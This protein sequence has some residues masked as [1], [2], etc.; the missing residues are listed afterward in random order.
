[1]S[2]ATTIDE[3][4]ELTPSQYSNHCQQLNNV[5]LLISNSTFSMPNEIVNDENIST[6]VTVDADE[7]NLD[8]DPNKPKKTDKLMSWSTFHSNCVQPPHTLSNVAIVAPLYRRSPTNPSVLMDIMKRAMNITTLAIGRGKRTIITL[9]GDLYNRAVK[10]PNYKENWIIR[11]GSLHVIIAALKCLGK[12]VEGSGIDASWEES[13]MFGSATVNQVIEGRHIYRGIQMKKVLLSLNLK[14][15]LTNGN[16]SF[17]QAVQD[18]QKEFQAKKIFEK[19]D[20]ENTA[21]PTAKFLRNYMKQ[22]TNLLTYIAATRNRNWRQ[23]LG[24]TEKMTTYIHA[25]NQ[26]NY[27]KWMLLYLGDMLELETAD[28][29]S[30]DFLNDGN[31]CVSKNEIPFTSIDPDH[32]IEHEHKHFKV[33]GGFVGITGNEAALERF[34]ITMPILSNIAETFERYSNIKRSESNC[35]EHHEAFGNFFQ[36]QLKNSQNLINILAK[37]GNPFLYP[38]LRNLVNYSVP[39]DEIRENVIKRDDIGT[40]LVHLFR[41]QRMMEN[42]TI[43]F[44]STLPRT[45]L[46]VFSGTEIMVNNGEKL[47]TSIR[48]EKQMYARM[49]AISRTRSELCPD[50][51]IDF[52]NLFEAYEAK[53][54][55]INK[56]VSNQTERVNK[57]ENDIENNNR[58]SRLND[59]I[60]RGVPANQTDLLK[61]FVSIA[62]AI[63]FNHS[64]YDCVNNIFRIRGNKNTSPI[65]IQFT[66]SIYKREFMS[67]YFKFGQLKL[68]D[69]GCE[70]NSRIYVSDN[71]TKHNSDIH[72]KALQLIKDKRLSKVTTRSGFIF[73]QQLNSDDIVKVSDLEGLLKLCNENGSETNILDDTVIE[74]QS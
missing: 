35:H 33:R 44:W 57:I 30:W 37:G 9:D 28:K 58:M 19:L 14:K 42:S 56:D 64:K 36:N 41:E 74:N 72:H 17:F 62:K 73:V 48:K 5:W 15:Q 52:H 4:V 69:I 7:S 34:V 22:V 46:K 10:I 65:I 23:H 67:S 1:M 68:S 38:D 63:K 45:N 53:L 54:D 49:L 6:D 55:S 31:F 50:K 8:I 11:L 43:P 27:A 24:E 18:A 66:T 20:A 26:S 16:E 47:V 71:L 13:G 70:S 3:T 61:M 40:K 60:I 25:H 12:Y 59:V 51:V 2:I 29:E 39:S 32:A 21:G